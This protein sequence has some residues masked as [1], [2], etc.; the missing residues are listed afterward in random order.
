MWY[1]ELGPE[2]FLAIN[3]AWKY[4]TQVFRLHLVGKYKRFLNRLN[5]AVKFQKLL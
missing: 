4:V 5:F 2:G 1:E 3:Y